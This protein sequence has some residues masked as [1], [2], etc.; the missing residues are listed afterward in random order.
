MK[1]DTKMFFLSDPLPPRT[2]KSLGSSVS[3]VVNT[4]LAVARI[5]PKG[6]EER[7]LPDPNSRIYGDGDEDLEREELARVVGVQLEK[8]KQN[9]VK[10]DVPGD[11][12]TVVRKKQQ[13]TKTEHGATREL[14]NTTSL[15]TGNIYT[16]PIEHTSNIFY[17]MLLYQY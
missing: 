15:R 12:T 8:D 16:W 5:R 1:Y 17:I 13:D 11:D 2:L 14:K 6:D 7:L 10:S 4:A 3:N 9:V